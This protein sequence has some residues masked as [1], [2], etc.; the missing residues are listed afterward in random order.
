MLFLLSKKC[1][2]PYVLISVFRFY[3]T[4]FETSTRYTYGARTWGKFAVCVFVAFDALQRSRRSVYTS[5]IRISQKKNEIS[6]LFLSRTVHADVRT[7]ELYAW[8]KRLHRTRCRSVQ[9][10]ATSVCKTIYKYFIPS[11]CIDIPGNCVFKH[12]SCFRLV[13]NKKPTATIKINANT[14]LSIETRLSC[15]THTVL[16]RTKRAHLRVLKNVSDFHRHR[17][18][19]ANPFRRSVGFPAKREQYENGALSC[20]NSCACAKHS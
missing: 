20:V 10:R 13:H 1:A 9:E 14:L 5:A 19:S 12:K 18:T 8:R 16:L 15:K 6:R 11:P 4:H 3:E 7:R 17:V 2:C